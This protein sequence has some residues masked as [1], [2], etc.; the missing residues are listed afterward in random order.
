[1]VKSSIPHHLMELD[2]ARSEVDPRRVMPEVPPG[3]EVILDIGC[4]VGQTLMALI[5]ALG[6]GA[7]LVGMDG[8]AAAVRY[9]REI[10]SRIRF[11]AGLGEHIPLNDASVDFVILR[12]SLPYMRLHEALS[13]IRR[14]LKPGGRAWFAL[15]SP[16][17]YL[18]KLGRAL[19]SFQPRQ[20]LRLIYVL[21]NTG[22]LNLLGVQ[23]GMP[24]G[25]IETFQTV[26]MMT[27]VLSQHGF[28]ILTMNNNR[29]FVIEARA[30]ERH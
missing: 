24:D 27:R 28:E 6:P 8:D 5:P 9:G 13:E 23:F 20:I 2:I 4:G 26:R 14:V 16:R 18:R 21:F 3:A 17:M 11:I 7:L 25:R 29:H 12:L 19:R 30:A 15:H 22:L 1:M 10:P